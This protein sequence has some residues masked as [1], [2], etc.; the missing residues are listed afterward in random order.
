MS[1]ILILAVVQ[2]VSSTPQPQFAPQSKV[3]RREHAINDL[4][5]PTASGHTK[6]T[7]GTSRPQWLESQ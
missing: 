1:L 6:A 2:A 4:A 5:K 7:S 3:W